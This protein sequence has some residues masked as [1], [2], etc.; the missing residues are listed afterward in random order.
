MIGWF[1]MAHA[2]TVEPSVR[3]G[4]SLTGLAAAG[5]TLVV[6]DQSDRGFTQDLV[7]WTSTDR[8]VTFTSEVV[9][10]GLWR[11][12][13][14]ETFGPGDRFP[15][16]ISADAT[17]RQVAGNV[18]MW[19]SRVPGSLYDPVEWRSLVSLRDDGTGWRWAHAVDGMTNRCVGPGRRCLE[20]VDVNDLVTSDDAVVSWTTYMAY[21]RSGG[22]APRQVYL[23]RMESGRWVGAPTNLSDL[24]V[25][26][27]FSESEPRI[28]TD[29]TG[30]QVFVAFNGLGTP[31]GAGGY[32]GGHT[33]ASSTDAGLSWN[34]QTVDAYDGDLAVARDSGEVLWAVSNTDAGAVVI[35]LRTSTDSGQTFSAPTTVVTPLRGSS[36]L[37][38][39][40]S[41]DGQTV[42]I[43]YVESWIPPGTSQNH[44][45][46]SEDGGTTWSDLRLR[47]W[48]YSFDVAMSDDGDTVYVTGNDSLG[49]LLVR[50]TRP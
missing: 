24:L 49:G 3:M 39:A 14:Y 29:I 26:N 32:H 13:G 27:D 48:S 33:L 37:R 8:G 11:Q 23:A 42:A 10:R 46:V 17:R 45:L 16:A 5:D 38:V 36:P 25:P 12:N 35:Q 1:A 21:D 20:M 4:D 22:R 41:R 50:V 31:T 19:D 7:V 44:L 43:G 6:A 30:D 34:T 47:L 2:F 9:V 18:V 40:V 15:L 28:A